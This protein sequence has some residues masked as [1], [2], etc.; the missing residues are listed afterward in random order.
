MEYFGGD[1]E[2]LKLAIADFPVL[3]LA[4]KQADF[5]KVAKEI[6]NGSG[7]D[8]SKAIF[9]NWNENYM[10]AVTGN[11]GGD[12]ADKF[13]NSMTKL[14]AVKTQHLLDDLKKAIYK[15]D[16]T[17]RTADE[18]NQLAGAIVKAYNRYQAVEYNTAIHR[19][20]V[21]KQWKQFQGEKH[22]YPNIEWLRTRSATPREVH[23]RYVGRVWAMDDPFWNNNQPG[24]VWNCK[25]SWKTTDAPVTNNSQ[26]DIVENSAG[27]DGN[28]YYTGELV[29]EKHPYYK[30][31]PADVPYRGLLYNLG[32]ETV[33][34]EGLTTE[35]VKSITNTIVD[36]RKNYDI[37]INEI[38]TGKGFEDVSRS[39]FSEK[40]ITFNKEWLKDIEKIKS[41]LAENPDYYVKT[42]LEPVEYFTAHELGHL[43]V[44]L[45]DIAKV[46]I[47]KANK[48]I[49]LYCDYMK[50]VQGSNNFISLRASTSEVP[51]GI[52][53]FFAESFV[54][55][56]FSAKKNVYCVKLFELINMP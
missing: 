49:D 35:V 50:E 36:I 2:N 26:I 41:K 38:S 10:K 56:L 47:E 25:C 16:G 6:Y 13:R 12:L 46:S 39:I 27:L 20:R 29:T 43:Y 42:N 1:I 34:F 4:L 22:L 3:Q 53:E 15:P 21:A 24:C 9:N 40:K 48:A 14:A 28:P 19:T 18:Y 17:K 55:N 32:V 52:D 45:K 30:G 8:F 31:V 33:S 5:M 51:E 37:V 54:M 7:E 44:N 11:I 23:L